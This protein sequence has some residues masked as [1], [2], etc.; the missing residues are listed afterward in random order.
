[1]LPVFIF[2]FVL[3]VVPVIVKVSWPRKRVSLMMMH[4]A[5]VG[6]TGE[7]SRRWASRQ[8]RAAPVAM[9]ILRKLSANARQASQ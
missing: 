4:L 2:V 3:E 1:L 6:L 8:W 9:A 5:H 7:R